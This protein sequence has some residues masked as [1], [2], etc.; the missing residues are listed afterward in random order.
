MLFHPIGLVEHILHPPPRFQESQSRLRADA[1]HAGHVVRTISHQS[2]EID[3]PIRRDAHAFHDSFRTDEF[4][5]TT[6]TQT[7]HFDSVGH[8]LHEILIARDEIR[9][10]VFRLGLHRQ[11][12]HHIVRLVP[13][14]LNERNAK[15][16]NDLLNDGKL[17]RQLVR[18]LLS[19]RFV[20][21]E[22]LVTKRRCRHIERARDIVRLLLFQNL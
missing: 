7:I 2:Q 13:F 10:N 21:G 4:R 9:F 14:R 1:W 22:C 20:R 3:H 16:F 15:R 5:I 17:I 12:P 8:E 11:C 6:A 18:H 19:R